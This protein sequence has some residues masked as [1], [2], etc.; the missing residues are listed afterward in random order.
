MTARARARARR[1]PALAVAALLLVAGGSS[2]L[3]VAFEG[4]PAAASGNSGS[5]GDASTTGTAL[6]GYTITSLAEAVTA[7][8]EQPNFPIP[9]TPSLEFDEGYASTED[10]SGPTGSATA[11][12]LYPGQVVADSGPQLALLVPGVPL[13]PAPI[14][15]IQ[16]AS[17]YPETPN[18]ANTDNAGVNMDASSTAGGNTASAT[19]GDDNPTAGSSSTDPSITAPTGSGNPFAADSSLIGIGAL[20]ATSTSQ[21][22]S[23]TATAE[24][25]ATDTGI[26]ILGGFINIGSVT[27]TATAASNG[28]TGT[29]TGS[30]EVQNMTIAGVPV[31]VDA[32]GIEADGQ[33]AP[34]SL[35]ISSINT[36]L[37]ELGISIAL[38]N[39]TDKTN[40]PSASRTLQ[41]LTFTIDL[42]TL[43]AAAD[44]FESLLPSSFTSQLPVALPDDQQLTLELAPVSVS[45]T[46]S[47]PFTANTGNT[48]ATA[49]AAAGASSPLSSTPS[50][51]GDSGSGATFAGNT[52]GGGSYS[53]TSSGSTPS[54]SSSPPTGSGSTPAEAIA[55]ASAVT[56]AFKGVGA[57]LILLGLL[58]ASTLAYAYKR[59]DDAAQ[60]GTTDAHGDPLLER[61][62]AS[63]DDLSDFGG[64]S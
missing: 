38:T 15:P 35:P 32:S 55:P 31:T 9:A 56:P 33:A 63:A 62:A 26:S 59:A 18:S 52:G 64:L 39:A 28:T 8:Y 42:K 58:A 12:S 46:A 47:L 29:L 19:L 6:G 3:A 60:L 49:P 54:S 37:N 23:V 16:A 24:A 61:F 20:S 44:Q 43:D 21:A 30:T 4:G 7:Q 10:N 41:G 34:L 1:L 22:P 48:G 14:W 51:T 25:S 40:G 17:E 2:L 5:G 45:S 11:S 36:L 13:P 57:A 53:P 50:V 27:S